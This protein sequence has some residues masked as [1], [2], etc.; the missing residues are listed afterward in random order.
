MGFVDN[1]LPLILD[2]WPARM[3]ALDYVAEAISPEQLGDFYAE[4]ALRMVMNK[5]S[6]EG[7]RHS[8]TRTIP[9]SAR[10]VPSKNRA[11]C[12][13]VITHAGG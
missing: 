1:G 7:S 5:G 2:E 4:L 11:T 13:L 10:S 6:A 3:T 12:Q 8:S 9:G